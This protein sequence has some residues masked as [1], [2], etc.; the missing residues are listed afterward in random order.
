[1]DTLTL[2]ASPAERAER[3]ADRLFP[4]QIEGV[5]FLLKRRRAILADDMGLGKTRQAIIGLHVAEP[6]GPYLVVCPASVKNNWAREIATAVPGATVQIVDGKANSEPLNAEWIIINYDVL[7]AHIKRLTS[8]GW[9][10]LVFDEAHC[11]RNR[12]SQ[13]SRNARAIV[14]A[15]D[16][17]VVYAL[18]GTPLTNRPRDLFPLLQLCGHPLTRSFLSFAKRYCDAHRNDYGWVTDGA[19]HL[20]ELAVQLHGVMLRRTKDEVLDLPPKLRTWL[21]VEVPAGT[22]SDEMSDVVRLL[23][24][25]ARGERS[26]GGE[27]GDR[28]KLLAL[29]TKARVAIANAKV[30]RTIELVEN[31]VAQ[32]EKVIVFSCFDAPVSKIRDHFG[33][34]AVTLTGA[35][36]AAKRQSLVDRFQTDD[37]ARDSGRI[38]KHAAIREEC[39]SG[40]G[41][42]RHSTRCRG[43]CTRRAAAFAVSSIA[44]YS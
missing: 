40:R 10:G 11:L 25:R 2:E 15:A 37:S 20:D 1:M 21:D 31:A 33:S 3:I 19:S 18:T 27:R 38:R 39:R 44:A 14:N 23:L 17:P 22:G 8:H 42:E 12:E 6:G 24:N 5:A 4:H 32:G 13:R 16:D 28:A 36:P 43:Q 35:T 34:A 9:R 41:R 29:L 26:R 30:D 7:G